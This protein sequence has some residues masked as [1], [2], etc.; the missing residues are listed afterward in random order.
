[1]DYSTLCALLDSARTH[2]TEQNNDK[3]DEPKPSIKIANPLS[4]LD[5]RLYSDLK[6]IKA[7]TDEEINA[8]LADMTVS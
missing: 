1:M 3:K 5:R 4:H 6:R 7:Y 8:V 2:L